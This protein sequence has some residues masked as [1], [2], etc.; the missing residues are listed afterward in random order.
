MY[1]N[2]E[3][4]KINNIKHT[5]FFTIVAT[6]LFFVSQ[7]Y[8]FATSHIS[9]DNSMITSLYNQYDKYFEK[10]NI[11]V[12]SYYE[13][14]FQSLYADTRNLNQN[15]LDTFK[16]ESDINPK[17]TL[18]IYKHAA[19]KLSY[20]GIDNYNENIVILNEMFYQKLSFITG[21]DLFEKF[22][23][24][25]E[26]VFLTEE[27]NL[28]DNSD[29]L[30]EEGMNITESYENLIADLEI[31]TDSEIDVASEV[32][33]IDGNFE[34]EE[35]LLIEN[36][37]V[38]FDDN[39]IDIDM[40]QAEAEVAAEVAAVAAIEAATKARAAELATA[41]AVESAGVAAKAKAEAETAARVSAA[42]VAALISEAE[43]AAAI[44]AEVLAE[45][46]VL[47]IAKIFST[48]ESEA[49]AAA[50]VV[51]AEIVE[52]KAAAKVVVAAKANAKAATAVVAAAAAEVATATAAN[53]VVAAESVVAAA[54]EAEA[55]AK[56][57]A[58]AEAE[59]VAKAKIV[60]AAKAKVKVAANVV[61]SVK[62]EVNEK[63]KAAA[64]AKATAK[65]AIK[66]AEQAMAKADAFVSGNLYDTQKID[67]VITNNSNQ[68][69]NYSGGSITLGN[70]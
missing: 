6:F 48:A 33:E 17:Y 5:K 42:V 46:K 43:A 55:A 1:I 54:S 7:Q 26:R 67:E 24:N 27:K 40:L 21:N 38:N 61:A 29:I 37:I 53:V 65:A 23:N 35:T 39:I 11:K 10:P 56:V 20:L 62:V 45:A 4:S 18:S 68:V 9:I 8:L 44:E 52:A 63:A 13:D 69:I 31:N 58:E 59:A 30:I 70:Q 41:K 50:V 57:V 60:A 49:A 64:K 47:E 12:Y 32:L 22:I 66:A 14:K 16:F 19:S 34:F 15:I 25:E 2:K 36:D 28:I 3:M 51:A